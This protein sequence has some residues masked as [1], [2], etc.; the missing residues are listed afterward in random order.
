MKIKKKVMNKIHNE[1]V[2]RF[3]PYWERKNQDIRQLQRAVVELQGAVRELA[4]Y[5]LQQA[6]LEASEGDTGKHVAKPEPEI[7]EL[8]AIWEA[9]FS[10][11][12]GKATATILARHVAV[13]RTLGIEH[14]VFALNSS[15][16]HVRVLLHPTQFPERVDALKE[17]MSRI[18]GAPVKIIWRKVQ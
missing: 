4:T 11:F 14:S 9:R 1:M 5:Q 17:Q 15:H 3:T 13:L 2:R 8:P 16:S 10:V 7:P 6:G 12:G 18:M